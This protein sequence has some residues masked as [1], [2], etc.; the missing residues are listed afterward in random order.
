MHPLAKQPAL[1][2]L[3]T[4]CALPLQAHAAGDLASCALIEE[5]E[6]RLGCY[7]ALARKAANQAEGDDESPAM[8]QLREESPGNQKLLAGRRLEQER[9]I[10]NNAFVLTPHR[11]N[12]LLPATYNARPNE[13]PWDA[14]YPDDPIQDVE[15]K[16]QF[17][18]KALI[19]DNILGD[20]TSLWGAYTQENWW[21]LYNESSPF[22]ETNYQPEVFLAVENDWEFMGF[23]NTLLSLGLTHQS[24][25]QGGDLSRSWNRIIAGAIF[26]RERMTLSARTWYRLPENDDEDDNPDILDN[27]GYGDLLGVWKYRQHEFSLMLRNNLR[28]DNKSAVQVEWTFPLSPRFKG[29]L[30][31]YYGYGENLIDQDEITNRIGVGISLTDLL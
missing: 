26:E 24:N 13:A 4:S 7:D 21:Q 28:Q 9:A 6:L 16:F 14:Q 31:Y 29:Y 5:D 25:G 20:R 17:S 19:W 3:L 1:L 12:Y 10:G 2:A 15:A 8:R 30:Q 18:V 27:Y 11:R 23:T 22:R